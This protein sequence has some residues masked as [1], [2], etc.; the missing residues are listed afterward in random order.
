MYVDKLRPSAFFLGLLRILR[1][2]LTRVARFFLVQNTKTVKNIPNCHE[3]HQMS[4]KYTNVKTILNLPKFGFLVSKQT[5]WQPWT[6]P[7]HIQIAL[8]AGGQGRAS[9]PTEQGCR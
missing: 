4:I 2:D 7:D 6:R 1:L 9:T 3:L 5:I 8:F